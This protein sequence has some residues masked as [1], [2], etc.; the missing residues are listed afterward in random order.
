MA[1]SIKG[2]T[3][4]SKDTVD[5]TP[6]FDLGKAKIRE[7]QQVGRCRFTFRKTMLKRAKE[8]LRVKVKDF[9]DQCFEH[10]TNATQVS[11][12]SVIRYIVSTATFMIWNNQRMFPGFW[13]DTTG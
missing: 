2:L 3:E 10:F 11:N 6:S 9:A 1:N 8:G 12:R 5:L 4:I 13:K 7:F